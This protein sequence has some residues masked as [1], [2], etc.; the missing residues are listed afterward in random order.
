MVTQAINDTDFFE[1]V[2]SDRFEKM[3]RRSNWNTPSNKARASRRASVRTPASRR[4]ARHVSQ[5]LGGK[6]RRRRRYGLYTN[7]PQL[8]GD[9]PLRLAI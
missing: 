7:F 9:R 1:A 5:Q 6:H 4:V 3:A 8:I 2:S